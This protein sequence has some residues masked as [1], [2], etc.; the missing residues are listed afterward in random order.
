QANL[1]AAMDWIDHHGDLDRDGFQEYRTRSS[2]GYY[3]QG[4]KDAGDAIIHADG[5]LAPLPIA[6]VELQGYAYEAKLRLAALYD[7]VDRAEEAK[8]LRH[9]AKRLYER[10]NDAFWWEDEGT[11][12]L[13]LDGGKQP[14][15]SVASN[16]GQLLMT[17][18]VPPERAERLV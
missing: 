1:D 17:G 5:S 14:I 8:R 7:L 18:I 9:Q 10:F 11:Y 6:L 13:G 3:N 2:H 15:R 4:W 16:P 12:Y